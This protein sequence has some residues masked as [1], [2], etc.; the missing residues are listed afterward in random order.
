MSASAAEEEAEREQRERPRAIEIGWSKTFGMESPIFG[1]NASAPKTRERPGASPRRAAVAHARAPTTRA[2][3]AARPH[4]QHD[5][6]QQHDDHVAEPG[7]RVVV[8]VLLDEADDDGGDRRA[9]D[10]AEAADHDDDEGEDQQARP[11]IAASTSL[12]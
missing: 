10:R 1:T 9:A 3:E 7:R 6:E 2:G 5:A 12:K 8:R 4:E 11:L